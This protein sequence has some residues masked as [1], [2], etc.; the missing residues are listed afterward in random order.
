M[1]FE[2]FMRELESSNPKIFRAERITITVASFRFQLKRAFDAGYADA[3]L[4]HQ[5]MKNMVGGKDDGLFETLFGNGL[6]K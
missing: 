6:K 5:N 2:K 3:N 1:T 4:F